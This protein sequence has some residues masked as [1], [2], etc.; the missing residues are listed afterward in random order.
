MIMHNLYTIGYS[1][2][3]IESLIK[4]LKKHNVKAIADVRSQPF[5]KFKPEFNREI[6]SGELKKHGIQYVFLGEECG[7][8]INDHSCYVNGKADYSR[9]ATSELFQKGL[10]RIIQG[11]SKMN[12]ALMCAEK[13]PIACHRTILI[14]HNLKES[15]PNIEHILCDNT[16]ETHE[17]AELRLKM[18]HKLNVPDMFM[19]EEQ[20]LE[21]AYMLQGQE[22]A[23]DLAIVKEESDNEYE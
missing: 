16:T 20:L 2:H 18:K 10:H 6:L 22:I 23:Y 5:S 1:C 13:D 21:Q 8:R 17:H 7:A 15:V 9:I 11:L 4:A 14:C 3:S 19:N 12:I